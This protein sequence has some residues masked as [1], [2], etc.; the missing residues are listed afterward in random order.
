MLE[1][2]GVKQTE[3]LDTT[4]NDERCKR[5]STLG[6]KAEAS[7]DYTR[8]SEVRQPFPFPWIVAAEV[9]RSRWEVGE[10]WS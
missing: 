4:V 6:R 7:I 9:K 8:R 5:S 10:P 3:Y 2:G 1:A